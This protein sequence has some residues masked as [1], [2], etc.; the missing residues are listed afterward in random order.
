MTTYMIRISFFAAGIAALALLLS[1]CTSASPKK[2]QMSGATVRSLN[3]SAREVADISVEEPGDPSSGGGGDVL[4]PYSSG[5][6]MCCFAVPSVWR[7]DL[8][9]VVKYKFY[10]E[11]QFRSALVS[12]PPYPNGKAS[13]IWLIVHEDESAEAVVSHYGPSRDE[14]PGKVKGYP[15]P[16]REYRLKLWE[17]KLIQEKEALVRFE[18]AVNDPG[19]SKEKRDGYQETI[20]QIKVGIENLEKRKP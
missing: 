1:S 12:V 8:K 14:W 17:R 18:K 2:E 7:P 9:V 20:R 6:Y 5:G 16:S 11:K 13:Q 10:P 4:N 19:L 15:V 3:Y